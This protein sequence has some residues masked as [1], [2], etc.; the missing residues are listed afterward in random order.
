MDFIQRNA[1]R[2]EYLRT[3]KEIIDAYFQ[4]KVRIAAVN[5]A[6]GR[7]AASI[8]AQGE[9][10]KAV[11]KFGALGTYLANLRDEPTRERYTQVT[12]DLEKL[13]RDAVRFSEGELSKRY[14]VAD[15]EFTA[16]NSDCIKSAKELPL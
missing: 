2:T 4:I 12:T 16:M 8:S 1:G 7:T 5:A 15:R 10:A 11:A 14:E 13:A 3:C 6:G 9:A